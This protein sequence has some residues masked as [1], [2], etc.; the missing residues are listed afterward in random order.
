M[1]RSTFLISCLFFSIAQACH[2]FQVTFRPSATVEGVSVSLADVADFDVQSDL[3]QA[4]GSQIISPSPPPGQEILIQ[5]GNLRQY[6]SGALSIPASVEWSGS[7]TIRIHRKGTT[8]GPEKIQSIIADFFQKRRRDLPEAE[9]HFT[10]ASL[11]LPFILPSGNLTW[12]VIPSNPGILSSTSISLIFTVDGHVRKNIAIA[13]HIEALAPVAVAASSIQ[14]GSI[15]TLENI[16]VL[17]RNIAEISSPCLD[18]RDIIGKKTNRNI[19]EGSVIER[20][21]TDTPP[22]VARGQIVKILLN[23]G[24]LHLATTGIA[25]MNG[26]KDQVIRVQNVNS[27]KLIYCRVTAP[28][29]VEVQL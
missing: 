27:K 2:G 20:T 16:H 29:I 15:M 4:L 9:I 13:G 5:T 24:E 17:P 19:K 14:R 7:E 22:M 3:A 28:G 6:L 25:N 1:I 11:P 8:V 12:E 23:T 26:T 10:P 18:P 21:W